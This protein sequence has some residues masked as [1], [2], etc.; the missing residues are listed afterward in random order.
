MPTLDVFK[1]DA[2]T[3]ESL[4]EGI[5]K[6]PYQP[7]MLERLFKKSPVST[8]SVLLDEKDNHLE[9]ISIEG[10]GSH[11]NIT[12]KATRKARSLAI[13]HLPQDAAVFA[14]EVQNIRAFGK[15]TE[16]E[17]VSAL[18]AERLEELRNNH[19]ATWEYHRAGAIQGHINDSDGSTYLNLFTEFG[20]SETS[21]DFDLGTAGTDVKAKCASVLRSME[22][23]LGNVEMPQVIGFCTDTFWDALVNHASVEAAFD[24][25]EDGRFLREDQRYNGFD[26]AGITFLN[27]RG[28]IGSTPF[29][30]A[31]ECRFVA[32]SQDI[33]RHYMAPADFMETVNTMGKPIYVKQDVMKYDKG[34]TLHSQS[35]PLIICTRPASL[36]R[37]HSST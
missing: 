15:E 5:N 35:N 25:W 21:V 29:I 36:I 9:L 2:F 8:T 30:T 24:R 7:R 1:A 20:I 13:P 31:G 32:N 17:T 12:K 27:Y 33:F 10:R 23:A 22:D 18:V 34:V 28:K 6:S 37:G 16:V 19:E 26:F 3:M 11:Q 14:D 4:T